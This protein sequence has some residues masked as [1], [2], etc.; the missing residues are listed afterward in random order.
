MRN[1]AGTTD[2]RIKVDYSLLVDPENG[3]SQ[4]L[5]LHL[6]WDQ[7]TG[8]W[9]SLIGGTSY[10]MHTT[11]TVTGLTPGNWY[12]F[13]YRAKNDFGWGIY[14]NPRSIQAATM[15][16]KI[17]TISTEVRGTNVRFNWVKPNI[18]GDDIHFYT[19][20]IMSKT[21]VY[22]EDTDN[23]D[24]TNAVILAQS[25]CEVPMLDLQANP[26]DLL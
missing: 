14:S 10:S 25:W 15:P 11:F 20:L 9:S 16:D 1:D 19:I 2:T 7:G 24:G 17:S 6:E 12:Q 4:V 8:V 23:C 18:R 22:Y 26:Y 13:R 21:G 3:G 5:T